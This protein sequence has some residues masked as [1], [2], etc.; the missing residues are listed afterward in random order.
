MSGLV[1]CD[2]G[3]RGGRMVK[4]RQVWWCQWRY[5]GGCGSVCVVMVMVLTLALQSVV[6]RGSGCWGRRCHT[7]MGDGVSYHDGRGGV[8]PCRGGGVTP[9]GGGSVM[10]CGVVVS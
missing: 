5:G 9:C 6:V 2:G 10:T 4:S 8:I 1:V 7:I 3:R